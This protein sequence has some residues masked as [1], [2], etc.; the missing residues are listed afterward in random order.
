MVWTDKQGVSV[1]ELILIVTDKGGC[2][3]QEDES[4]LI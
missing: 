3:E 1:L 4:S 2:I